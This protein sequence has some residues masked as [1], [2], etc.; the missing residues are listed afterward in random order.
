MRSINSTLEHVIKELSNLKSKDD[1]HLLTNEYLFRIAKTLETDREA[2]RR[3][4][5]LPPL[6]LW[7]R[8]GYHN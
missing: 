6:A 1:H 3:P 8:D 5:W 2:P 7:G 4:I